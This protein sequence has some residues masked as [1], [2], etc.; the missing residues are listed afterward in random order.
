LSQ[1]AMLIEQNGIKRIP[2]VVQ[3]KLVGIVS[4]ANLVQ[5]LAA[6]P[7]GLDIQ[8]G[9]EKIRDDLM[10]HL[11]AQKW[12]HTEFLNVT[13]N[14][15]VVHLWGLAG[16]E[17]ER[18]AIRIAAESFKGVRAVNDHMLPKEPASYA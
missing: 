4:R 5:A 11:S 13:V 6:V 14:D 7:L 12:A 17:T 3:G 16:S 18:K 1:I 9:D 15:G 8:P 2:V 10:S